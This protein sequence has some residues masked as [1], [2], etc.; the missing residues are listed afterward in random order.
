MAVLA[1]LIPNF[2]ILVFSALAVITGAGLSGIKNP[3]PQVC[4]KFCLHTVQQPGITEALL[5][6]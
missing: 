2:V 5:P 6:A 4:P 1:A 3:G